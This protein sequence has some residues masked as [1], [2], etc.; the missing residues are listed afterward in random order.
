M[1]LLKIFLRFLGSSRRV[2]GLTKQG[3]SRDI[4]TLKR[5]LTGVMTFC[6]CRKSTY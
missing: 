4:S 2:E 6:L 5:I 1:V 3:I